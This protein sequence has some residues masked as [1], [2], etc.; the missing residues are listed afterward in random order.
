MKRALGAVAILAGLTWG[1]MFGWP[2]R[3]GRSW[4]SEASGSVPGPHLT[5]RVQAARITARNSQLS[6]S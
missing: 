3:E 4:Y 1:S 5:Q 6:L 2:C